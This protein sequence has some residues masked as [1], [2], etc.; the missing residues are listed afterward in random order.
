MRELAAQVQ[1]RHDDRRRRRPRRLVR[2]CCTSGAVDAFAT[3]DVL[4][5]GLIAQNKA[6]A[7]YVVVGDF[8]SYDP[9]G[10]HVP[11]GRRRSSRAIVNDDLPPARRRAARSSAATTRWFLRK[12]PSGVSLDLPM[13]PQ[14]ETILSR[15]PRTA[16]SRR[17]RGARLALRPVLV[18]GREAR[19]RAAHGGASPEVDRRDTRDRRGQLLRRPDLHVAGAAD[20][21]VRRLR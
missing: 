6:Q 20:G 19:A 16:S 15:W 1:A 9:Y 5:Y 18:P 11:Q 4:L 12:L 10:H 8:L 13:S 3:D 21:D 14:L 17:G 7:D 2:A